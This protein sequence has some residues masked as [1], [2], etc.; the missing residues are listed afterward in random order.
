MVAPFFKIPVFRSEPYLAFIREHKCIWC[1]LP[2]NGLKKP[3]NNI[4][5]HHEGLGLNKQSGKPPDSH[6]VPLCGRCHDKRH[7]FGWLDWDYENIDIKMVIIRLLTE[8][9]SNEEK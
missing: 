4:I 8:Y 3:N 7:G 9:L 6:A 5:A 1:G 2:S